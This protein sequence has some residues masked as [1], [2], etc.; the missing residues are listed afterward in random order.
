MRP[1]AA[2][3]PS[4]KKDAMAGGAGTGLL[5]PSRT[6][7]L[8][9][10]STAFWGLILYLQSTMQ[11]NIAAI[12]LNP[13]AFSLPTLPPWLTSVGQDRCAGRRVYMYDLPPRFN[14]DLVPDYCRMWSLCRATENGGFGP[15]LP[16][17]EGGALP[18]RGSYDTEMYMLEMIFHTRM[19]HY[20][21]LTVDA[22]A[23]D[24][25]FVPYYAGFDAAMNIWK[26][27]L[28]PRDALSRDLVDWL[29]RRPEWRAMGGRDHFLVVARG[30]WDFLRTTDDGWGN[31]LLALPAIRNTTVLTTE[32]SPWLGNDFAVPFPS[33]FHPASD[34]DVLRWQDHVRR[35]ERRWL[36]AFAGAPRPGNATVRAQ[37]IE[38][39]SRSSACSLLGRNRSNSSNTEFLKKN[40]NSP[41]PIMRLLESAEF[42]L[43][44]TGDG[45]TRKST[46]DAILA[47]C[48]PVFFHP[49]SAYTQ[50]LWHLPRDYRSYSV[51]IP[52]ADVSRRNVSIEAVLRKIPPATV[53]RMR[54]EVIRL[55]PSVMYKDPAAKQAKFK[56]AFD[57]TLEA[58]LRRVAKR[59][60]AAAEGRR[61]YQDGV[62]G[63]DSWK[64]DLLEDG[65]TRVVGPHELDPYM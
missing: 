37:I 62:D 13:S 49:V 53:A 56:D 32:A 52:K 38:Q 14:A 64:Y 29:Q 31:A 24:A 16:G 27:D 20:E 7:Y 46:F 26:S 45:Y 3:L 55:I 54:E 39:C 34:A 60:R 5:R 63:P 4:V 15:E 33:H 40:N 59:R 8:T 44:P 12:S 22:A 41:G 47:G 25:V 57:I 23:A 11:G 48:I 35:L 65:Q 1:G 43:Q 2:D 42:C 19:R 50:Y 51:F 10:I 6:C 30:S 28:A 9:V 21:C 58:V 17:G 36:W 18:E 61:E